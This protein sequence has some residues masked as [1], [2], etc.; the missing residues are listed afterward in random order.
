MIIKWSS[1]ITMCTFL[2]IVT[3]HLPNESG[4]RPSGTDNWSAGQDGFLL[5][6]DRSR[7]FDNN[8]LPSI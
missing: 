8:G 2:G 5:H 6:E 1:M 3:F 7:A 4:D